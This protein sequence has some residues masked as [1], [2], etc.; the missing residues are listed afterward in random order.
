MIF[1]GL[2]PL[3]LII[4]K[5][6]FDTYLARKRQGTPCDLSSKPLELIMNGYITALGLYAAS[7]L[8]IAV[9]MKLKQ[10]TLSRPKNVKVP[11]KIAT[12]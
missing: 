7:N 1:E 9:L 4:Q 2:L 6:T 5:Q 12:Q 3:A 8:L 11:V 10:S